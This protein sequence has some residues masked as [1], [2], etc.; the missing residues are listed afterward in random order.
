[1]LVEQRLQCRRI[2]RCLRAHRRGNANHWNPRGVCNRSEGRAASWQKGGPVARPSGEREEEGPHLA[3]KDSR[4]ERTLVEKFRGEAGTKGIARI[5]RAEARGTDRVTGGPCRDE[6]LRGT[7]APHPLV[8][9]GEVAPG[10]CPEG[11]ACRNGT[12]AARERPGNR[13]GGGRVGG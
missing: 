6:E 9:G 4:G 12:V 7:S 10:G 8:R 1:M 2:G 11:W 5:E 13:V 3:R